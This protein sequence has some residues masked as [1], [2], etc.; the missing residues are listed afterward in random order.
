MC[1]Q[2]ATGSIDLTCPIASGTSVAK[3]APS[4]SPPGLAQVVHCFPLGRGRWDA[5]WDRY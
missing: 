4:P 1:P 3:S 5:G 2:I